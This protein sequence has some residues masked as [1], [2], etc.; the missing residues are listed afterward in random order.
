MP[1]ASTTG[2]F[3]SAREKCDLKSLKCATAPRVNNPDVDNDRP[4]GRILRDGAL[5]VLPGV[6]RPG[7]GRT[8][9]VDWQGTPGV[10]RQDSMSL[11][12]L[13]A[14][15]TW[16]HAFMTRL[17]GT[18][19]PSRRPLPAFDGKSWATA[20]GL[21]WE[22]V[23]FLP[24]WAVGWARE[25]PMEEIGALLARYHAAATQIGAAGQRPSALPLA[26]V[27]GILLSRQLEAAS[28]RLVIH[29]AFNHNVIADGMPPRAV[30]VIDF[31]LAHAE[32]PLADVGYGLWR[33]GRP[34][35]DADHLDLP[36]VGRF[37]RGYASTVP[38]SADEA[39]VISLYIRGRGLQMIAK[40]VRAGRAETGTLAQVRWLAAN[41]GAISD[42]FLAA[43]S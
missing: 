33:S 6:I 16:L 15:V 28:V 3:H 38:A 11:A 1:K 36:R 22:V 10:L 27:P 17:A 31:A 18:G 20:L 32:T 13:M 35:Q 8:W 41:R 5:K 9:L 39:C 21:F 34:R 14:D 7:E 19:F 43:H 2:P 42:E 37:L 24:G 23:S 12:R 4:P 26:E 29:G 25:P 30:G 40:R